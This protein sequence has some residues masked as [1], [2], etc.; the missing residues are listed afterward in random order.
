MIYHWACYCALLYSNGKYWNKLLQLLKINNQREF[1]CQ[2]MEK[3]VNPALLYSRNTLWDC[4]SL[5]L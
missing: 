5:T 3:N 4:E 1:S 2:Y